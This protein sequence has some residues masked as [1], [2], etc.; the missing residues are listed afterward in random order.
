MDE[1]EAAE[2]LLA[3]LDKRRPRLTREQGVA[4]AALGRATVAARRL[5]ALAGPEAVAE[6]LRRFGA[7]SGAL[8]DVPAERRT[9]AAR[10]M[11]DSASRLARSSIANPPVRA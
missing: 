4:L 5:E 7:A 1:I 2:R 9:E 6:V 3:E 10:A 11:F 8:A